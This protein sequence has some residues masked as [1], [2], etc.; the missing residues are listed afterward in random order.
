M[1]KLFKLWFYFKIIFEII[2]KIIRLIG[3]LLKVIIRKNVF[4]QD[5]IIHRE[6][7]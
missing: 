7:Q 2:G 6:E 5:N 3:K 4:T 1:Y